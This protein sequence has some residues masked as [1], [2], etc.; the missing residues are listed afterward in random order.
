MLKL[1]PI[2]L[3]VLLNTSSFAQKSY[4]EIVKDNKKFQKEM[5][6]H[7]ASKKKSPLSEADRKKFQAIPFFKTDTSY[8]VEATFERVQ[9]AR[10]FKMKTSGP[11]EPIYKV[12]GIVT[13]ELHGQIFSLNLYQN[14]GF[15]T[16]KEYKDYL[17]LPFTDL[18]NSETSY[19]GGRYIDLRI[20]EGETI[21]IDFNQAYNP[22]CAYSTG[23]N[24]PIP[25]RENDMEIEINAGVMYELEH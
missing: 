21:A 16:H 14:Q 25:P 12:F 15:L 22:Y 8:Y 24:C 4:K 17:F 13:F 18:T 10:P 1:L 6:R 2:A 19:G 11:K 5:N 3:L 7:Y 23:Y 9:D 20:P